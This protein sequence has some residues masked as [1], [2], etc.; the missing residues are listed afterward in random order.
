MASEDAERNEAPTPKRRQEARERGEVA[1]ST[2][3]NSA[4]LL[5]GTCG[6]L[7]WTGTAMGQILIA[8]FRQGLQIGVPRDLTLEAVRGLLLTAAW[9]GARAILPVAA[10]GAVIGVLAN[11]AQVGFRMTPQAIGARWDRIDPLR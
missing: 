2:E 7:A 5:L 10:A 9:A 1:R 8:T 11:I 6:A 4:F 3:L